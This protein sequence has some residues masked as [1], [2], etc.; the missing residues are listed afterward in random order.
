MTSDLYDRYKILC[1]DDRESN[2]LT[3]EALLSDAGLC[4]IRKALSGKEA[5]EILLTEKIDLILLDVKMPEMDGFELAALIKSN[6][7]TR[8]IPIVFITAVFKAEEF[9]KRGYKTGAIDYITKPINDNQLLNKINLYLKLFEKEKELEHLNR[10]LEKRVIEEIEK[11][12]EKE[13]ILLHQSKMAAMGEMIGAIAHQ[14]RQPLNALGLIVQD[15]R[16]ASDYDEIDNAYINRSVSTA[17]GQIEFMSQTIDDFRNFFK[18]TK[19]RETFSIVRSVKSVLSILSAMFKNNSIE[20]RFDSEIEGILAFKGYPNEFKQV[21]V[22]IISNSKDA[23]LD[24][25]RKGVLDSSDGQISITIY[26]RDDKIITE[27]EDNG[28]GVPEDVFSRIFE[29]YFTTKEQG[30]GTGIGLYMSKVI[31]ENNMKGRLYAENTQKGAKFIIELS[32]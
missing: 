26:N 10:N 14:W 31:I 4:R 6:K 30:Q 23:I 17:M 9:L 20:V 1:V 3:L 7:R 32:P 13:Q 25:R 19:E 18:S 8:D 15:L 16:D 28:G 11:R 24:S 27:I 5:L 12:R 2:L 29:P 22:N 21:I